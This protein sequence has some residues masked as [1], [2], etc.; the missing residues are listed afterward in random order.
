VICTTAN[1]LWLTGC[2]GEAGRF[3][4]ATRRVRHAQQRLLD[5]LIRTNAETEFGRQHRFAAIRSV[6]DY[7][8][9]VPIR[10]YDDYRP[11]IDR[12]LAGATNVL[13]RERVRLFEPTSGSASATK[14]VPYTASLQGQ[15]QRGIQ[16]WVVDLFLHQPNLMNG[17]AYWSV[18]PALHA[19]RQ[20]VGG[21]PIGFE[22]DAD[23]VGAWRRRLVRAVMAVPRSVCNAPDMETFQHLTLLSLIRSSRLRFVSVWNPTFLS[24]LVDRL[25]ASADALMRDLGS[26]KRRCDVLRAAL[27]ARTPGERHATLWPHLAVISC[28]ADANAAVPAAELARLF[29]QAQ[30]QAKGLIATEGF[31]SFPQAGHEGSVLAI[32]SHFLE[33]APLDSLDRPSSQTPLTADSLERGQRYEVILSNGGGLYRYRLGDLVEVVG[34]INDCPLIRFIGRNGYVSD[35]FGEKLNEAHV[36]PVLQQALASTGV[37]PSFAMLACDRG[38]APPAYVLYIEACRCDDALHRA[39]RIIEA[40]LRRNFHYDYARRL[41]QLASIR[42]F[43]ADG[44]GATYLN[45]A[46]RAGQRA[47]DVKP[48]ALDRRD[49]WSQRFRGEFVATNQSSPQP[50]PLTPPRRRLTALS[51]P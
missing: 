7:Q 5:A 12:L 37:S 31:I 13:T 29:P 33:F 43:R 10:C 3:R 14:L 51:G 17:Q 30:V 23:Y 35:W 19:R 45:A 48:L 47:G 22:D 18:S 42:V 1:A 28:W 46:M 15:F 36:A 25:Q 49:G 24:L 38:L 2:L 40:E 41:G 27:R 6:R 32:R 44:A 26:D 34:Y 21:I 4:R 39:A 11:Y 9:L 8:H 20:T 16:A 50:D